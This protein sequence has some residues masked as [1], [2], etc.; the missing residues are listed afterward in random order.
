MKTLIMLSLMTDFQN[1][2]SEWQAWVYASSFFI[3]GIIAGL[4]IATLL[5]AK[6]STN[7][8]YK[9]GQIDAINGK[10]KYELKE[11]EDKSKTWHN[12]N[13]QNREVHGNIGIGDGIITVEKINDIGK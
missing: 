8:G 3:C 5:T 9:Q 7:E 11:N 13:Y 12:K 1:C 10:I 4:I 2:T 6:E